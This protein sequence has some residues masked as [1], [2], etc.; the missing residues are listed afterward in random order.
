MNKGQFEGSEY[1]VNSEVPGGTLNT[2]G[3]AGQ[4]LVNYHLKGTSPA[5]SLHLVHHIEQG[6]APERGESEH[7]GRQACSKAN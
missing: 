6:E 3:R 4:A 5:G 7:K 1:T 2:G